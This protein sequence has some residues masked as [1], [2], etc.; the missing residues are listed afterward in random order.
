L[1]LGAQH[2]VNIYQLAKQAN[3]KEPSFT[4]GFI[5][6]NQRYERIKVLTSGSYGCLYL[7]IDHVEQVHKVEKFVFDSCAYGEIDILQ[8]LHHPNLLHS[9]TFF[10]NK[11]NQVHII[12][13]YAPLGD[14]FKYDF[15][16]YTD[17]QMVDLFYQCVS[18]IA[19]LHQQ[20]ICHSDIKPTNILLFQ[21]DLVRI[22]DFGASHFIEQQTEWSGTPSFT[23]P[24]GLQTKYKGTNV[25]FYEKE[26][27][28]Q[29]DIF[30]LGMTMIYMLRIQLLFWEPDKIQGSYQRF[31]NEF[32]SDLDSF[33]QHK[34]LFRDLFW[35]MCHPSQQH[36]FTNMI[37]VLGH[38]VFA[39]YLPYIPVSN[40]KNMGSKSFIFD[41]HPTF[42]LAKSV[43]LQ[44]LSKYFVTIR[45]KHYV[46]TLLQRFI[47]LLPST[48][49]VEPHVNEPISSQQQQQ[50]HNNQEQA[51]NVYTIRLHANV[52]LYEESVVFINSFR[53]DD[54][55]QACIEIISVFW[56]IPKFS[57]RTYKVS[58]RL[59]DYIVHQL[60]GRIFV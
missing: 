6:S 57:S 4:L 46:L 59:K 11:W 7:V 19:H 24:Q 12:V 10:F 21:P 37:Q 23:S 42:V 3:N 26:N 1:T 39:K 44:L 28:Y 55:C 34:P 5:D 31:V 53:L 17:E 47:H 50:H 49:T 52:K 58:N 45:F 18:A 29:T 40:N 48:H 54:V 20:R 32:E 41:K 15:S 14:C 56:N 8:R 9:H 22:C 16:T 30:S 27:P 36:R 51:T 60:E 25:V 2:L 33:F 38:P 43:T 35:H 13:P